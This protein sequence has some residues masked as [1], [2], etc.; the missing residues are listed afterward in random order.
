MA[1]TVRVDAFP[2]Q[3]FAGS[4]TQ[5]RY[6]PTEVQGVVTYAAVLD[7]K[8][9]ELKLRP[10]MTATVTITTSSVKGVSAVRNAALR[11][12]PKEP[13][14]TGPVTELAP[15]E[16]RVYVLEDTPGTAAAPAERADSKGAP[17][18]VQKISPRVVRV[19][20]SDGVWTELAG[21]GLTPGT[22]VVTEE[23]GAPDDKR[24]KFLGIF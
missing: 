10:G 9:D 23:R 11:F 3:S 5:I 19:G 6:N 1:A 7:V 17:P 4:L 2:E 15:G 21:D 24:R 13:G 18:P 12:K 20:I 8:N 14:N 16:R 22:H